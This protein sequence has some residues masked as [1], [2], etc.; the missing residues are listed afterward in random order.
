MKSW[1]ESCLTKTQNGSWHF[2]ETH[3]ELKIWYKNWATDQYIT[4]ISGE[5]LKSM[6]G[7][8]LSR[9]HDIFHSF[10]RFLWIK[11]CNI[12]ERSSM[13]NKPNK[14]LLFVHFGVLLQRDNNKKKNVS[15]RNIYESQNVCPLQVTSSFEWDANWSTG[16]QESKK[17]K[18][19]R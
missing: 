18:K 9:V 6:N 5:I 17:K 12:F 14:Y 10:N 15:M 3:L 8:T 7:L 13:A 11:S 4:S 16:F 1:W 2:M 19:Q